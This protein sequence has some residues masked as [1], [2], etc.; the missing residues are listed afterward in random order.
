M[1]WWTKKNKNIETRAFEMLEAG[2]VPL[3]I[4]IEL[5]ISIDAAKEHHAKWSKAKSQT[6]ATAFAAFGQGK[7]LIAV[8]AE[9]GIAVEVAE[10]LYRTWLKM[11]KR[12]AEI[13]AEIQSEQNKV[14]N[15]TPPYF[16]TKLIKNPYTGRGYVQEKAPVTYDEVPKSWVEFETFARTNGDGEYIILDNDG[17]RA[18]RI[19]VFGTGFNDPSEI[20][21][22][23][24]GP[25][26]YPRRRGFGSRGIIPG[27]G[28][29]GGVGVGMGGQMSG[30][31]DGY[32]R[33]RMRDPFLQ[34]PQ[35]QSY[36]GGMGPGPMGAYDPAVAQILGQE[37][38]RKDLYYKVAE[39]ATNRGD[40]STAVKYLQMAEYADGTKPPAGDNGGNKKS[41]IDEVL[42]LDSEP[43][44]LAL[45]KKIFGAEKE[46]K[47]EMPEDMKRMEAYSK[48]AEKLIPSIKANII[49]PVMDG[50]SGEN[51]GIAALE[52]EIGPRLPAQYYQ[53]GAGRKIGPGS[54]FRE[55]ERITRPRQA[56]Q[57]PQQHAI[58]G[59]RE[60]NPSYQA[61]GYQQREVIKSQPEYQPRESIKPRV[62]I[63]GDEDEERDVMEKEL[64]PRAPRPPAPPASTI[65][66]RVEL[67]P[68]F[69][70]QGGELKADA[71]SVAATDDDTAELPIN[72][73][74]DYGQ[75][76]TADDLKA[77][78]GDKVFTRIEELNNAKKLS[79][80]EKY[81]VNNLFPRFKTMIIKWQRSRD[82]NDKGTEELFSPERTAREDFHTMTK[83][84]YAIFI[85]KKRLLKSYQAA[86]VG[87]DEIIGKY[88][89]FINRQLDDARKSGM[90]MAAEKLRDVGAREFEKI[91]E[92]PP[93]MDKRAGIKQLLKYLALKECWIVFSTEY[94][95]LWFKQYAS[96]FVKVVEEDYLKD[97]KREKIRKMLSKPAPTPPALPPKAPKVEIVEK[98]EMAKPA[99]PKVENPPVAP[100]VEEKLKVE[101][102]KV[103]EKPKKEGV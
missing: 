98:M 33:E 79:F 48:M 66:E 21:E 103:E 87:F 7:D 8:A 82:D 99:P 55:V 80:D 24:F 91:W 32:H 20:S 34:Q 43:K 29:M 22:E 16:V 38:K 86:K 51:K 69:V 17:K 2:K 23:Q 78:E 92:P 70:K 56:Q 42:S 45:L 15:F 54:G 102:K 49:E 59:R 9:L 19:S 4:S 28:P 25:D 5:G 47:D 84:S 3:D 95:K 36:P 73:A 94:G 101:E 90:D 85:G 18:G 6:Q 26:G 50:I 57:P 83:S 68:E 40:V 75:A 13:K 41:F 44:K 27:M 35:Q 30:Y 10:N 60:S 63:D 74:D 93:G 71:A 11:Q 14:K 88:E 97:D 31:E 76:I 100:K 62:P 52:R 67:A 96:E 72:E 12:Q 58:E 81:V 1:S 39:I 89:P 65:K 46:E 53:Q 37:G 77:G 61:Q 64:P